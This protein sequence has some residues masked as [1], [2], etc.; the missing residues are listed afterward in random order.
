MLWK[1]LQDRQFST[2]LNLANWVRQ[3]TSEL[4]SKKAVK[5]S[6]LHH[7]EG[8]LLLVHA[9]QLQG[10]HTLPREH[11]TYIY[12]GILFYSNQCFAKNDVD[13]AMKAFLLAAHCMTFSPR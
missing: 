9:W 3:H 10:Q 5:E 7:V 12:L 1:L 4:V 8:S 2:A 13:T 11:L 6:L